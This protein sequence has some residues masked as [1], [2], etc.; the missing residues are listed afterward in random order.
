M[1]THSIRLKL[2]VP[3][4][5]IL[6]IS[7]LSSFLLF[8]N[9]IKGTLED[10]FKTKGLALGRALATNIQDIL[11]NRDAST[12]Q[13]LLDQYKQ[14]DGVSYLL[15][16]NEENEIISHTFHP[17]IPQ[18]YLDII[19]KGKIE[20]YS[21]E[22]KFHE[23]VINGER[24]YL[25]RVPILAGLLGRLHIGMGIGKKEAEVLTPLLFNMAWLNAFI[26]FLASIFTIY[27]ISTFTSPLIRLTRFVNY[28]SSKKKTFT[29]LQINAKDEV[30]KLTLAFNHMAN[31]IISYTKNLEQEVEKRA[32]VIKDQQMQLA[33]SAKL[34]ALGEMAAG[35]A[36]EI[37]NPL[38]IIN[39]GTLIMRKLVK[40][41]EIDLE[42]MNKLLDDNE[43]TVK[44]ITKIIHGLR[45]L[46]R[47]TTNEEMIISNLSEVF[48][49][50]L[51]LSKDKFERHHI[52]FEFDENSPLLYE[53]LK[54]KPVQ[55]SQVF[56]NLLNN[57]FDAIE[58]LEEKWLKI[59]IRP[60]SQSLEIHFEDSGGGID[61]QVAQKIF[62]PFFTTKQVGKGTGLGLS[63]SKK[64]IEDHGGT[65]SLISDVHTHFLITLPRNS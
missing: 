41:D 46:S 2:I 31:R 50:V 40:R 6:L 3:I 54:C 26:I 11:L 17:E 35:I 37:N 39:S 16:V 28:F 1:I 14:M 59:T 51:S 13:A 63:L 9:I 23:E 4:I 8:K 62:T 43:K 57:A 53:S 48:H 60:S 44:R 58:H 18:Y 32:L 34:S 52:N 29:P 33:N 30:G 12:V 45:N 42:K 24:E 56:I 38:T 10:E 55:L 21:I 65:L 61:E 7:S 22:S 49:D 19:R 47:D 27:I 25:I 5:L 15:I 64:I 20:K 36:H